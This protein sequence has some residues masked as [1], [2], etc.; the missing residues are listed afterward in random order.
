MTDGYEPSALLLADIFGNGQPKPVRVHPL[1]VHALNSAW[2]IQT[3][4]FLPINLSLH[5]Y[6]HMHVYVCMM[7]TYMYV[8]VY[9]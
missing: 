3:I 2:K 6:T 5:S 7:H 9:T 4:T 1:A 8:C